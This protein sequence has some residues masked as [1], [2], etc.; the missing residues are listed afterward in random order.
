MTEGPRWVRLLLPEGVLVVTWPAGQP[1]T[2]TLDGRPVS[3]EQVTAFL[4]AEIARGEAHGA[5]R[6]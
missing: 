3:G 5:P 1:A 4:E 2:A 6:P